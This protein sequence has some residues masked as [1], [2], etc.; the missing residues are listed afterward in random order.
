[1][2]V[3]IIQDKENEMLSI[4]V[5]GTCFFYGNYW[6]FNV[7][8]DIKDLIS[9]MSRKGDVEYDFDQKVLD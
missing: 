6:D 1:M 9:F 2:K 7:P 3:E 4:S 8:G 5:N